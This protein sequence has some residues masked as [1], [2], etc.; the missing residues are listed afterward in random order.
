MPKTERFRALYV[1]KYLWENTDEETPAI[2]SRKMVLRNSILK[3]ITNLSE[4][5]HNKPLHLYGAVCFC[6]P[7]F[8]YA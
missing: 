6:F 7:S 4:K 3:L 1:L 8:C 5:S 2:V